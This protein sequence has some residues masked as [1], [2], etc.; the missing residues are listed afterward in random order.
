MSVTRETL[1]R[2]TLAALEP[3]TLRSC[4]SRG[5]VRRRCAL[6][7]HLEHTAPRLTSKGPP[8]HIRNTA[9]DRVSNIRSRPLSLL[10][11]LEEELAPGPLVVVDVVA[12]LEAVALR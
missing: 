6:G 8:L 12:L 11:L 1:R 9:E 4:L 7:P 3:K 2:S 10:Q 5:A